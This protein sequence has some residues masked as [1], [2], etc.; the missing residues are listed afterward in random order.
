MGHA[1]LMKRGCIISEIKLDANDT[2]ELMM[3]ET[4]VYKTSSP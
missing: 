2:K 4:W 3:L 1:H